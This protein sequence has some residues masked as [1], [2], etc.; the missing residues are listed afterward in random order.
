MP[1]L[2]A[3]FAFSLIGAFL[4]ISIYLL[5]DQEASDSS[6]DDAA[7]FDVMLDSFFIGVP[8]PT[9]HQTQDRTNGFIP[10]SQEAMNDLRTVPLAE[11]SKHACCICLETLYSCTSA[12][13]AKEMPCRHLFHQE[14]IFSWL[15]VS[16][17][18]PLC[19]YG[20]DTD[21][22]DYN[23]SL[24]QRMVKDPRNSA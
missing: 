12:K 16:N 24:H 9:R 17:T 6:D 19:R 4:P 13:P 21:N 1:V 14:C 11:N 2:S 3:S 18:C 23:E 10:A 20:I 22:K 15:S 5:S 7:T 8:H